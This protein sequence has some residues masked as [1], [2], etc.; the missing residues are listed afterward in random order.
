MSKLF[1]LCFILVVISEL[2]YA[3]KLVPINL[4][5]KN[6]EYPE[7]YKRAVHTNQPYEAD[8]NT[9]I[10][11]VMGGGTDQIGEYYCE[12][13]FGGPKKQLFKVDVDTGSSTM[14]IPGV[15][16]KRIEDGKSCVGSDLGG[17]YD[18]KKSVSAE[19]QNCSTYCDQ[20]S[21]F[22]NF[23]SAC[24]VGVS[25]GDGS[26]V[27][28]YLVSDIV[29]IGDFE[30]RA[31]FAQISRESRSFP[32]GEVVGLWGMA[33]ENLA[34]GITP[35]FDFFV[36]SGLKDIFSMCLGPKGGALVLGGIN[37]TLYTGEIQYTPIV[38]KKYY[39]VSLRRFVIGNVDLDVSY[40]PMAIIDSGTTLLYL[41]DSIYKAMVNTM[42][43]QCQIIKDLPGLCSKGSA[44]YPSI[45]DSLVCWDLSDDILEKYPSFEL[46][47]RGS[48]G[49]PDFALKFS[50]EAYFIN[51]KTVSDAPCKMF[52]I[53]SAGNQSLII[54][55]DLFMRQYY[56]VFDRENDRIGFA[57]VGNCSF[58]IENVPLF[59]GRSLALL[60]VLCVLRQ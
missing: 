23:A 1:V 59:S 9:I 11:T 12:V 13:S 58:E 8:N 35:V 42:T 4:I 10:F 25:Y 56:I 52:G 21:P 37:D 18:Y 48:S 2:L 41:T 43:A 46:Y 6:P 22:G 3:T 49:N 5:K 44:V 53:K 14:F 7:E 15:G 26:E 55:G 39:G 31:L 24:V 51:W 32:N 34:N 57:N 28:G 19:I 47:F 30:T 27:I 17:P 38:Q 60:V 29:G 33:Y 20:C 54:I 45:F 16:C 40:F 36:Q 50:P